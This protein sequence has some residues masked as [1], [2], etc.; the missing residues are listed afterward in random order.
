MYNIFAKLT[1]VCRD[2]AKA[3]NLQFRLKLQ[4]ENVSAF[5]RKRPGAA[6]FPFEKMTEPGGFFPVQKEA[7]ALPSFG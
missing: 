3:I 2:F 7:A 5:F 4:E 6:G 1:N